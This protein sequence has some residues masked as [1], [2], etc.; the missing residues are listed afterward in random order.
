MNLD[1]AR[2]VRGRSGGAI[3]IA[4]VL[5]AATSPPVSRAQS[6]ARADVPV[7]GTDVDVVAVPVFVTD[8]TGHAVAGL[9]PSDFT[10]RDEGREA[11]VVAFEEIDAGAGRTRPS[12]SPLLQAAARRQFL[13]LFDLTFST[14]LGIMKSRDAA[15][16][17]VR[18]E[19][20]PGD[21]AAVATYG[22]SGARILVGFTSDRAQLQQAIAGLGIVETERVRDPL[23]LAWDLALDLATGPTTADVNPGK[24]AEAT[25]ILRTQWQLLSRSERTQY[26]YRVEGFLDGLA[27]LAA[28]LDGLQGRKDV[29]LLSA[30][31]DQ[32]VLMGE[33]GEDRASTGEAVAHGQYWEVQSERHFGDAGAQQQLARLYD[34]LALTDTVIHTVDVGG[35]EAA[36]GAER[37]LRAGPYTG[38]RETLAQIALGSGGRFVKDANDI[39]KGLGEILDATRHYYVLAFEPTDAGKR[40]KPRKLDVRVRGDGLT[41]SHRSRYLLADPAR[42]SDPLTRQIQLAETVAK[43]LSGGP[44]A[45]RAVAVPYRTPAGETL[46][47][48]ALE[49]DAEALLASRSTSRLDLEIYGYAFDPDGRIYDVLSL[50]PSLDVARVRDALRAKGL[51]V[52]ASF[53]VPEGPVDLRFLVRESGS[54]L[55]GAL[56]VDARV[57][58]FGSGALVVSPPLFV[59]DPRTRV[60]LPARSRAH[61]QLEIPFRLEDA[62]F[63]PDALPT[64]APR[65]R[66]EV[67]VLA[68]SGPDRGGP[69]PWELDAELVADERTIPLALDPPR[70]VPDADGFQRLVVALDPAGAAPGSYVLRMSFRDPRT[71]AVVPTEAPL[72]IE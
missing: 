32:T 13:L 54:G 22:Q 34:S 69:S 70:V 52:L 58:R 57:P 39:A 68:W 43:G 72:A 36:P 29:I 67:C 60:V 37:A 35:L 50:R 71:G 62:P 5:V 63:T 46:L 8:K 64:F 2:G 9:S 41:V 31:F 40:D 19:L 11:R 23:E 59:D 7:F 24:D 20:S 28:L 25:E 47:S 55:V 3:L 66:H 49:V 65:G 21:L 27:R 53:A 26:R 12:A 18:S 1:A 6:L 61:P 10:I 33:E 56:R 45:L 38:G 15:R 44:I 42:Q 48:V 17:F 4:L 51:Q 30:G 14:P 16:E